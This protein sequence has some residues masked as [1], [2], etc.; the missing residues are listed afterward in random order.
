[1]DAH[2]TILRRV[3]LALVILGCID[4]GFIVYCIASQ[5]SYV[6]SF[7]IFAV[8]AGIFL[9]KGNLRAAQI[10]SWFAA[11]LISACIGMLLLSPFLFPPG[12]I[13]AYLK[14]YTAFFLLGLAAGIV[15]IA[16]LVWVYR[17]LTTPP[18]LNAMEQKGIVSRALWRRPSRGF[19]IGGCLA[20]L[21]FVFVFLLGHGETAEEARQ[22]AAAQVGPGYA[23]HVT[24]INI[25]S[26]SSGKY[27]RAVVTAYN[28]R[29]IKRIEI[30]WSE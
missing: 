28:D 27:V 29:E 9:L 19:W 13:A 26:S 11:L 2:S 25:S 8:V 5:T 22:R 12:L 20:V 18:V 16:L 23:F 4:I 10:V 3:G 14:L 24:S 21:L 6:S 1:M 15:I 7:N 30:K 17:S